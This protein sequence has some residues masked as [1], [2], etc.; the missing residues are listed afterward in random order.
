MY[1]IE[2]ISVKNPTC[3][4]RSTPLHMAANAGHIEICKFIAKHV[5]DANPVNAAGHTP[6]SLLNGFFGKTIFNKK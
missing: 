1:L 5:Q 3:N 2:K 6:Q 4:N